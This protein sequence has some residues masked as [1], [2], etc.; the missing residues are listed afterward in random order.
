MR[1]DTATRELFWQPWDVESLAKGVGPSASGQGLIRGVA[2]D[3]A[4]DLDGEFV[5][6][7]GLVWTPGAF[8][9]LEHPIGVVNTIGEISGAPEVDESGP[10]RRT[11]VK[12]GLWLADAM[13]KL[14]YEKAVAMAKSQSA[15]R[16]GFSVEGSI[17]Q[18]DP[19]NPKCITKARVT[20]LAVT[21]GPRNER[22]TWEP[23]FAKGLFGPAGSVADPEFAR[24]VKG[25]ST[26]DLRVARVLKARPNAQVTRTQ[27]VRLL[28][29]TAA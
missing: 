17:L 14:V 10:V 23:E 13:G 6:Q 29:R 16:F 2:S 7:K 18:R 26:T 12:A 21:L 1:S 15:R 4:E 24:L 22:A 9:T 5:M 19:S 11:L 28:S 20:S 8:V 27:L 3:E 25:L